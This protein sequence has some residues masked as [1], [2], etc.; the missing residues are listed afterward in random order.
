MQIRNTICQIQLLYRKISAEGILLDKLLWV[1]RFSQNLSQKFLPFDYSRC[2]KGFL[3][4]GV[5]LA[6]LRTVCEKACRL[7]ASDTSELD[8][9]KL[10][11]KKCSV[12][13]QNSSRQADCVR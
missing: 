13:A 11:V 6:S 5:F 1:N 7:P 12:S 9:Q 8:I 10:A 3:I 2:L 4:S